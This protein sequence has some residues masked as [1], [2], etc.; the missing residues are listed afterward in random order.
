MLLTAATSQDSVENPNCFDL[1]CQHF[2]LGIVCMCSR[3]ICY[4]YFSMFSL[5]LIGIAGTSYWLFFQVLLSGTSSV[6]ASF[7]LEL[8]T[9][10]GSSDT[11][12][13]ITITN[14]LSGD[15][16][17]LSSTEAFDFRK[18]WALLCNMA[19]HL[20]RLNIGWQSLSLFCFTAYFVLIPFSWTLYKWTP[21]IG[22]LGYEVSSFRFVYCFL[23]GALC[24][25]SAV[26][27]PVGMC[28]H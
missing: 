13:F 23:D 18:G 27:F 4:M 14:L 24:Y 15:V 3:Q 21:F 25:C 2:L 1:W 7:P 22:E 6:F 16:L 5:L 11:F 10:W 8:S 20:P 17:L 26:K 12:I 9:S 19:S 28:I